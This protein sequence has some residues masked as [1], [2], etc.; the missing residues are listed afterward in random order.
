M[1]PN[2]RTSHYT[3]ARLL[4]YI[5]VEAEGGHNNEGKVAKLHMP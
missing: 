5:V 2:L 3:D 1:A 4:G